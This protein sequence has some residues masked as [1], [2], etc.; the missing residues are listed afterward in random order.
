M[1]R[2]YIK[3]N[4]SSHLPA[5]YFGPDRLISKDYQDL[6]PLF[7]PMPNSRSTNIESLISVLNFQNSSEILEHDLEIERKKD[8]LYQG[9]RKPSEETLHSWRKSVNQIRSAILN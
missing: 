4:L 6:M 1:K 5:R 9:T 8:K 7:S 3:E 2:G